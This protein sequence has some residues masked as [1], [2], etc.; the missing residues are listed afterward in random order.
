MNQP[1][2]QVLTFIHNYFYTELIIIAGSL[3]AGF[4][5]DFTGMVISGVVFVREWVSG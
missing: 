1:M 4:W 3:Y 2:T 5:V